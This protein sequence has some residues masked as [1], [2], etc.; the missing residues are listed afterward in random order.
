MQ[1]WVDVL[2]PAPLEM[3]TEDST[4]EE[5]EIISRRL[6]VFKTCLF[7]PSPAVPRAPSHL[8]PAG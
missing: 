8:T 2:K 5:D 7:P 6:P 3:L 1:Q 4:P